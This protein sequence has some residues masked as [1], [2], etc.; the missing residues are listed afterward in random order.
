MRVNLEN[1]IGKT[2]SVRSS[3]G[4]GRG[5]VNSSEP[6]IVKRKLVVCG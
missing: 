3:T 2:Q 4:L 6:D 1:E 5:K